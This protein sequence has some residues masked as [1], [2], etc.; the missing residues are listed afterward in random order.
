MSK[1][2]IRGARVGALLLVA[3]TGLALAPTAAHAAA[4]AKKT[5]TFWVNSSGTTFTPPGTS[6][7]NPGFATVQAAV[8][9][10]EA[11]TK[12]NPVVEVC[13]GTYTEQ[14]TFGGGNI[15]VVNAGSSVVLAMPQTPVADTACNISGADIEVSICSTA[16][17]IV[18]ITGI[19][20]QAQLQSTPCD[21]LYGIFVGGGGNTLK[22]TNSTITGATQVPFSG[23]QVGIG[24]RV[25]SAA[26][27]QIGHATLKNDTV[28]DYQ[29]GGIVV[30]GTSSTASITS[31]TVTGNGPT[32]VTAQNGIQVSRGAVGTISAS[33]VTG[34]EYTGTDTQASGILFYSANPGSKVVDSTISDNDIGVYAIS[35]ETSQPTG[36]EFAITGNTFTDNDG[37]A[38]DLGYSYTTVTGNTISGTGQVG[39]EIDQTSAD[40]FG[41]KVTASKDSFSD[42]TTAAVLIT[43]DQD[44]SDKPGSLS[45]TKSKVSGNPAPSV[46]GSIQD[47][48]SNFSITLSKDT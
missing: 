41:I 19:E 26:A 18:S 43:S 2:G 17:A 5:N 47:E 40:K 25:G 22:L 32:G 7:A 4:A 14:V 30:D 46:I 9:A 31:T 1:W 48:S 39:L 21:P 44:P 28:Q 27:G 15:S 45:L 11:S 12:P 6:C 10:A 37:E 29:K 34:N 36:T 3:G 16:Q 42:Q 38:I 8:T 20:V 35:N 33:T 23:C 24:L 13:S